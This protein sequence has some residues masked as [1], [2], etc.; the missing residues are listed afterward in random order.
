MCSLQISKTSDSCGSLPDS[1]FWWSVDFEAA[2][3]ASQTLKEELLM[4]IAD[5]SDAVGSELIEE[6]NISILRAAYRSISTSDELLAELKDLLKQFEGI[7]IR[8]CSKVE[9]RPWH[10]EHLEAFPPLEAGKNFVVMAPWHKG[11][12]PVGRIPLYIYPA[13]AFGTGYHESTQ[14]ALTLMEDAVVKGGT[15]VDVGSGTG[16]LF[17]AA[18]KLGSERSV[19]RDL[20]PATLSEVQ[21]NMDLNDLAPELCDL[22]AGDLLKGVDV[23]ADILTANILLEPNIEL[24]KDVRRVLKPNGAAVFSGM[25][26][27]QRDIFIPALLSAGLYL[28]RELTLGEW[29]GCLARIKVS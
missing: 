2:S 1:S 12:E 4:T 25:T 19:A 13:S 7:T 18:L 15:A 8:S 5:L 29:W 21:R 6:K 9:N 11:K 23:K 24:L 16:V 10:T 28:E 14:I 27:N 20:D 3:D 22:A 17:I 26:S